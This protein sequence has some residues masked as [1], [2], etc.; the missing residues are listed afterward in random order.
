[1][2]TELVHLEN[3]TR[4]LMVAQEMQLTECIIYLATMII[5]KNVGILMVKQCLINYQT[6]NQTQMVWN[7]MNTDAEFQDA[8][9]RQTQVIGNTDI[10]PNIYKEQNIAG[11]QVVRKKYQLGVTATI[12][13]N[14]NLKIKRASFRCSFSIFFWYIMCLAI[15]HEE[16]FLTI[17][18]PPNSFIATIRYIF[19]INIKFIIFIVIPF[20]Q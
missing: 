8:T 1:M 7:M 15:Y 14:I 17:Y 2:L 19:W 5:V 18:N 13:G 9:K 6:Q 20:I 4:N 10:V 11:I 12:A 16:F 3:V